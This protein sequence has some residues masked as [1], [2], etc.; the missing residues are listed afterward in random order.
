MHLWEHVCGKLRCNF[1]FHEDKFQFKLPQIA[2]R[3]IFAFPHC[4]Q[5]H[6]QRFLAC[7][8]SYFSNAQPQIMGSS[9]CEQCQLDCERN[10]DVKWFSELQNLIFTRKNQIV[11]RVARCN[12]FA[13]TKNWNHFYIIKKVLILHF[14]ETVVKQI[15]LWDQ[16][17]IC[18][19]KIMPSL[20]SEFQMAHGNGYPTMS[21]VVML[22]RVAKNVECLEQNKY[23]N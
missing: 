11:V 20:E 3:C 18:V 9:H 23:W 12:L 14:W 4:Q 19:W 13:W 8:E 5:F 17:L 15:F 21:N 22:V 2:R 6:R 10:S 16:Q 1:G 7:M